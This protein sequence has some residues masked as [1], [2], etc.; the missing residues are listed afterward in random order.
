MFHTFVLTLATTL[1]LPV[2]LPTIADDFNAPATTVIWVMIAYFLGLGGATVAL[3]D[4]TTYFDRRALV[5]LGLAV[6]V[7]VM[8]FIFFTSSIYVFIVC[9]FLSAAFRALL[10]IILQV[11]AIG[12]FP[13][14]HR[15]KAIGYSTFASG[16]GLVLSTT[17]TGFVADHLG[18][19]WLFMGT[20]VVYLAMIPA[21]LLMLPKLP[22]EA[23]N[24]KPLSEFDLLGSVLLVGGAIAFI[25]SGQLFA[26]SLTSDTSSALSVVLAVAGVASLIAFVRVELHAKA[27]ILKFSVFRIPS[28]TLAAAQA[29]V[30]GFATGSILVMLPFMLHLGFGW[31]LGRVGNV[32]IAQNA[33]RPPSGPVAGYL[34]DKFGSVAVFL[35]AAAVNVVG[36]VG[37][38]LLGASPAVHLVIG[39]VL[40]WGT[41]QAFMQTANQRQIF[42]ALP[43]SQL[44]LAPSLNLTMST[45]GITVGLAVASRAIDRAQDVSDGGPAFLNRMDESLLL[46]TACFT[47]GIVLSQMLP[48][49]LVR[50]RT[51]FAETVEVAPPVPDDGGLGDRESQ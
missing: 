7:L 37:L 3:G 48:R 10:W 13:A 28:V 16:L 24:R 44:H 17:F 25:T 40:L 14:E 6:D 38:V 26:Q 21:V 12:G 42:T 36:Q 19:R 2:A 41:G 23:E 51:D 4:V 30:M 46:I 31:S 20:S 11:I 33:A 34:S 18:W 35:P 39:V 15:G 29:A 8:S 22:P 43:A 9:R 47:V 50:L 45:L 32:L 49:L 5:I 27:P 1:G